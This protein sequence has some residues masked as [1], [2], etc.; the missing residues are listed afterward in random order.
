[1]PCLPGSASLIVQLFFSNENVRTGAAVARAIKCQ[2]HAHS[3]VLTLTAEADRGRRGPLTAP[4]R[5]AS[6]MPVSSAMA[7]D[8]YSHAFMV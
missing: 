5:Q 8:V 2:W 7:A 4:C 6:I 1:M 3:A